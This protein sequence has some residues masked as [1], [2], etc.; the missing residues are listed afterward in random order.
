MVVMFKDAV[1]MVGRAWCRTMHRRPMWPIHGEYH[2][3]ICLRTYRVPWEG[4]PEETEAE[5]APAGIAQGSAER[6]ITPLGSWQ[7]SG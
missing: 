5:T 3:S 4:E 6:L 1:S 2:C 7:R